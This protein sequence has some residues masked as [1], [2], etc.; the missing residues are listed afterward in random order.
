MDL[1]AP[2]YVRYFSDLAGHGI[3]SKT[4]PFGL[5]NPLTKRIFSALTMDAFGYVDH[6]ALTM[7]A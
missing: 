7:D 1:C 2:N 5:K 6:S 3:E 4:L